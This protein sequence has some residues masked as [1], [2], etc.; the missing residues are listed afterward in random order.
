MK[1][2]SLEEVELLSSSSGLG[3][4]VAIEPAGFPRCARSAQIARALL[5]G[6]K[7]RGT[8]NVHDAGDDTAKSAGAPFAAIGAVRRVARAR[9]GLTRHQNDGNESLCGARAA[10]RATARRG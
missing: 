3:H 1:D 4:G 10:F 7:L 6:A 5:A 8:F 9:S 2:L